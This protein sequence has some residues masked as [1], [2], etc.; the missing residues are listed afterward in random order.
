MKYFDHEIQL[1]EGDMVFVY[2]DGV[3]E[4]NNSSNELFGDERML[5]ALNKNADAS[6]DEVLANV[7]EAVDAYVGEAEQFDDLTMLCIKYHQR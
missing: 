4:A 6:P 7:R 3:P 2:T 5:E 1:K